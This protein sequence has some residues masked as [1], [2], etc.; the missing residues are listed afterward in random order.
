MYEI[1]LLAE[2]TSHIGHTRTYVVH[3]PKEPYNSVLQVSLFKNRGVW[4]AW[5]GCYVRATEKT[6]ARGVAE[7]VNWLEG[8]PI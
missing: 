2:K 5:D 4:Y 1:R 3:V 7:T 8:N 6:L